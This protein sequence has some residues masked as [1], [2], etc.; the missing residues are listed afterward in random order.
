M[1][2]TT[3]AP[4]PSPDPAVTADAPPPTAPTAPMAPT[5][6]APGAPATAAPAGLAAL[7]AVAALVALEAVRT[8]GPLLDMAFGV[9]V[10]AVAGTALGT[11]L[12]PGLLAALLVAAGRR[13]PLA[14]AV[15]GAAVLAV[16][17]LV[18]QA[19]TA[20]ARFAV[21]LTSVALAVAV[22]VLAAAALAGRAGGGR[23]AAR[24]VALGLAAALGLQLAL[25][26]WDAP[27]RRDV[28]GWAVAAA[29]A[30]ALLA[31][32]WAA[33]GADAPARPGRLWA[34]GPAL[35][36]GAMV[37]ANPAFVASQAGT[38]LVGA[39]A[40]LGLAWLAAGRDRRPAWT[41]AVALPLVLAGTYLAPDAGWAP[42]ALVAVALPLVVASALAR[43]LEPAPGAGPARPWR[44][45]GA[46][47]L[48]GLGAI[49][50][51]LGYQ[52]DYDIPLPFPNWLVPVAAAL[53]LGLAGVRRGTRPVQ[54]AAQDAAPDAVP[55]PAARPLRGLALA[56]AGLLVVGA[57]VA[58]AQA[59]LGPADPAQR[60]EVVLLSWNLHYGVDPAG[61][62]DLEAIARTIE[63][64][65]PDVVA[66][67]EV[68]RGWV[69]GGGADM[70]T[71]LAQRLRMR[72]TFAPAADRQFGNAV[73]TRGDL[74]DAVA[75]ELPYGA[76][77]QGR[78]AASADV[79]LPA[80]TL[81]VTSVHLQHRDE[82]TPTRL[83][84]LRTLLA[85][86]Q[87]RAAVVAGDLNAQPGRPEIDLVTGAGFL[88]AVDE[89]GDPAALTI[90]STGPE[91]RID[92]VFW[93]ADGPVAATEARVLTQ[94]RASDHLP[95]VVRLVPVDGRASSRSAAAD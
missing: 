47:S 68:N 90:P 66:L 67:Q 15:A 59:L 2:T 37:A 16:L 31:A 24:S 35:G 91:E 86:E 43:A 88:S 60:D 57:V 40:L 70:A 4:E 75:L 22:L 26:S 92:W 21:G 55:A 53:A 72:V 52:I 28:L 19:L 51:L 81:R 73:L 42:V 32:A 78:S 45:A 80:G 76:G 93:R 54:D 63:A 14:A 3:P 33:R 18:L 10:V 12:A 39:G 34:L 65:D 85:A 89:V 41:D 30:A 56:A 82:N 49:L 9:G 20:G 71:W 27:W 25:G 84:Q 79:T 50:P 83:D 38:P 1:P 62:V 7:V 46:A 77:P 58:G 8:S 44:A 95:I 13:R 29:L 64:E 17:R 11:Y 87:H 74:S 48:V 69:Q 36:L 23:A 94:A 61:A 5:A 6:P